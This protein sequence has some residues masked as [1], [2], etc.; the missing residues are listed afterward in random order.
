MY[1]QCH[2]DRQ[3]IHAVGGVEG[4]LSNRLA[5]DGCKVRIIGIEDVPPELGNEQAVG[6]VCCQQGILGCAYG[7]QPAG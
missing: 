3:D 2:A 7:G 6:R 1:S 4:D 5:D